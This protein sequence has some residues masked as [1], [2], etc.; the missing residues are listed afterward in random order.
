[1]LLD[2]PRMAHPQDVNSCNTDELG[3]MTGTALVAP[4]Q[5]QSTRL[6]CLQAPALGMSVLC[7]GLDLGQVSVELTWAPG[8][9]RSRICLSDTLVSQ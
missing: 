1:M 9:S 2:D 4:D 6:V 8:Y 7:Q 3:C 5:I